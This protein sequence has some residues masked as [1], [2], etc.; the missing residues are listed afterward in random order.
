MKQKGLKVLTYNIHKGFNV[1]NQRFVLHQIKDAL[2]AVDADLLL[3]QEMQG[4]NLHKEKKI[5]DWPDRSL[6]L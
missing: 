1:G 6:V 5:H 2:R 4:K 3:L